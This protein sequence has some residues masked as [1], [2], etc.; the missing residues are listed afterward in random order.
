MRTHG[1]QRSAIS[2][3]AY[4]TILIVLAISSF[5]LFHYQYFQYVVEWESWVELAS[6]QFQYI[7]RRAGCPIF[8]GGQDA[9]S[10]DSKIQQRHRLND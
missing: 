2:L 8:S 4:G 3:G 1:C 10:T 9:H 7:L 6:C 5:S